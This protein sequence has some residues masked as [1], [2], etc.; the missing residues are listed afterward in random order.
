MQVGVKSEAVYAIDDDAAAALEQ[1]GHAP[2]AVGR[3]FSPTKQ[4]YRV[5][6]GQL[7]SELTTRR[8]RVRLDPALLGERNLVLV[9]WSPRE[10]E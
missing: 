3:E 6:A 1:R 5:E 7:S 9:P 2:L 8:L 10:D 4:L